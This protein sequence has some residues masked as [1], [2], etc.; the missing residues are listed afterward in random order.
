MVDSE[1]SPVLWQYLDT[2]E[3]MYIFEQERLPTHP[4]SEYEKEAGFFPSKGCIENVASRIWNLLLSNIEISEWYQQSAESR[5][6]WERK[7][8]VNLAIKT[9]EEKVR[10]SISSSTDD[11]WGIKEAEYCD[12][13][14]LNIRLEKESNNY[15][16]TAL[17][18]PFS[19]KSDNYDQETVIRLLTAPTAGFD[20]EE[21]GFGFR[22]LEQ[23]ESERSKIKI[24]P[25]KL[26][27]EIIVAPHA[28]GFTAPVL[29]EYLVE[30]NLSS[31]VKYSSVRS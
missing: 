29:K 19:Y 12:F 23:I 4:I 2:A 6:M 25:E 10:E 27:Q 18:D 3:L 24:D 17:F 20:I 16:R 31:L 5:A 8:S 1:S 22:M 7:H 21:S 30:F 28:P 15:A 26:I 9:T 14:S 13:P 11:E